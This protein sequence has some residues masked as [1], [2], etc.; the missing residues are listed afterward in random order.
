MERAGVR[1][2]DGREMLV[3]QGAVALERWFPRE[4]A[5]RELMRAVVNARYR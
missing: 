4:K 3:A 5:P 2:L 1:A